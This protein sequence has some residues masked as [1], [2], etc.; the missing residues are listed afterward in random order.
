VG[1]CVTSRRARRR[2]LVVRLSLW[3]CK[4]MGI[5]RILDTR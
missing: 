1:S 3:T 5:R 2:S 4:K